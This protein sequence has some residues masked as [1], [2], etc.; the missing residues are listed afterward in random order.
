ML[1]SALALCVATPVGGMGADVQELFSASVR[2][3]RPAGSLPQLLIRTRPPEAPAWK[4]VEIPAAGLGLMLPMEAKQESER[5]DSRV[6]RCE[7]ALSGEGKGTLRVDVF[8][9]APGDP[10]R[11]D[12]D[13]ADGYAEEYPE[14]AFQ[15]RFK[16]TDRGRIVLKNGLTTALV[17]GTYATPGGKS[18]YRAQIAFLS[19]E[20]QW[21]LT[22]DGPSEWIDE[23][24]AVLAKLILGLKSIPARGDAAAP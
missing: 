10:D 3:H 4:P 16:V 8:Q 1:W 7:I 15:G 20:R 23:H 12:D 13:Y 5:L 9:P 24:Q 21:F 11:I 6:L 2:I 17:G 14:R 19:R 18:N 22:Y